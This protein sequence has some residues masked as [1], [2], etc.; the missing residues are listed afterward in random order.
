MID[1]RAIIHPSAKIGKDVTIGP[2]STIGENVTVGEGSEIGSH[3]VISQ[4]TTIGKNNKIFPFASIG[5]DP[6]YIG[7]KDDPT[8]LEI[9]DGNVIREFVT[10]NRGTK[11]GRGITR[12]GSH[13]YFMAY[14]HVAHDCI[15]G[16]CVIFANLA[17]IAGHVEI[18]DHA[19]LGA[20]SG[21]HQFCRVGAYTFLGRA[22]KVYQDIL[23]YMLVTGNPAAPTGLNS[24]GLRRHGF[25]EEVMRSL[26]QAYHLVHRRDIKLENVC[27]ELTQLAGK[28]PEVQL[29][30]TMI[31]TS[32]RGFA[33][34]YRGNGQEEAN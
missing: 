4:N 34:N 20:Y 11:E 33:R 18:G 3:V 25:N 24:V 5:T 15:I 23:P 9:G 28:T 13:N 14:T 7:Y 17:Q 22:A 32:T 26:K 30:L 21:V 12:V 27:A 19:S 6:Q 29:L 8:W 1:Q 31:S 10:I 16:N 2:W